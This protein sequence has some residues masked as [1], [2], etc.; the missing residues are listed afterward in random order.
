[1][2][3][4]R[5]ASAEL[6]GSHGQMEGPFVV[7]LGGPLFSGSTTEGRIR[8]IVGGTGNARERFDEAMI[9]IRELEPGSFDQYR[10]ETR[11]I[12]SDHNLVRVDI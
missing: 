3:N 8:Y 9:K 10:T 6:T 4:E 1:M 2:K 11:Q 7:N 12:L 5:G